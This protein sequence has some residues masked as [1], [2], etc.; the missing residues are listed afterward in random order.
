MVKRGFTGFWSGA[1]FGWGGWGPAWRYRSPAFGWRAWDPFWGDPFFGN[2]MDI[3]T[4]DKYEAMAE[5]VLGKGPKPAN[6]V[7]A[8][9]AR[10]VLQ[11][12]G[13]AVMEPEPRR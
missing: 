3:R 9:D 8:F 6:N 11:S 10:A 4:V 13:P 2:T 12:L 1:G 5:I 7:R